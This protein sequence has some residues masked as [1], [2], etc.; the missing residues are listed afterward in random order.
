MHITDFFTPIV[1]LNDDVKLPFQGRLSSFAFDLGQGSYK[2][3]TMSGNKITLYYDHFRNHNVSDRKE[4]EF[5]S[6]KSKAVVAIKAISWIAILA[7]STQ[8]TAFLIIPAIAIIANAIFRYSNE[9]NVIDMNE[10]LHQKINE[11][12]ISTEQIKNK[13]IESELNIANDKKAL[14]S[15]DEQSFQEQIAKSKQ[16]MTVLEKSEL[17]IQENEIFLNREADEL[18]KKFNELNDKK[19]EL[20]EK[21]TEV[22]ELELKIAELKEFSLEERL[23]NQRKAALKASGVSDILTRPIELIIHNYDILSKIVSG[24]ENKYLY[25]LKGKL[26][27]GDSGT[28][29]FKT[30]VFGGK[31][32]LS[33]IC[34]H[35]N[36]INN[37]VNNFINLYKNDLFRALKD[38]AIIKN[39]YVKIVR[40]AEGLNNLC[41]EYQKDSNKQKEIK[42]IIEELKKLEKKCNFVYKRTEKLEFVNK[43]ILKET[44]EEIKNSFT[45]EFGSC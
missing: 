33:D 24:K 7:A 31:S 6:L 27:F 45:K 15:N 14:N 26:L 37:R 43:S 5:T 10:D 38:R 1:N 18:K 23:E 30:V 19:K 11:L 44:L 39:L 32:S 29:E 34:K 8:I 17:F 40:A 42:L 12:E 25:I 28:H 2:V 16:K 3:K 35:I 9:F 4:S 41:E 22:N 21:N 36:S 13:I 20:E